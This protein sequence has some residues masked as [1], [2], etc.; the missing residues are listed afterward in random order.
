M[1]WGERNDILGGLLVYLL[2]S[3]KLLLNRIYIIF[4]NHNRKNWKFNPYQWG[5]G[6]WANTYL[7]VDV[8]RDSLDNLYPWIFLH[9]KLILNSILLVPP[10]SG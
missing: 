2:G 8:V 5:E 10:M 1:T 3:H 7:Y 9:I 6:G 4:A